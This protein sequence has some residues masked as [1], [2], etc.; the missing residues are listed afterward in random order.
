MNRASKVWAVVL[1]IGGLWLLYRAVTMHNGTEWVRDVEVKDAQ[2]K[3]LWT[4]VESV[5]PKDRHEPGV[6]LSLSRTVGVWIAGFATLAVF[7]FLWGDNPFYKLAESL[8]VGVSAGYTMAVGFWTGIIQ[9]MF[10]KLTPGLMRNTVL[11]GLNA[12]QEVEWIYIVPLVLSVMLLLR[13]V[14]KMEWVSRW[15]LAFFIG[16][17][18]GMRLVAHLD[19]DF[20]KQLQATVMPLIAMTS[21]RTFDLGATAKN[22]TIIVGVFS[23]LTYFYFSAEHRGA[24]SAISRV[25]IW[26][27]MITFGV[28]FGYTVMGRVSLLT[29]RLEFL[30][31]DWL[32]LIDPTGQLGR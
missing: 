5:P 17:T 13:L 30:F 18:A 26:F 32:W 12:S 28:G 6:R 8:V 16:A 2:S 20:V 9:N 19:A 7:S 29:A 21:D 15:P 11:P 31:I 25:G 24:I 23:C 4:S 10:G 3:V 27:L 22:L 1:L 14:P